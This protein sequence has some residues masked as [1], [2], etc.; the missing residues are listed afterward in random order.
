MKL[1]I[2]MSLSLVLFLSACANGKVVPRNQGYKTVTFAKVV[3][4]EEVTIGGSRSGIGSYVGSLAAI[5]DG[6][7]NSFIGIVVRGVGGAIVGGAVEEAVTRK[8]GALYT[9]E[10]KNGSLIEVISRNKELNPGDCVRIAKGGRN[11]KVKTAKTQRCA[12]IK[13]STTAATT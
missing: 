7:R 10:T 13:T 2:I 12:H 8:K 11:A 5:A 1:K 6:T 4:K 9:V 3:D